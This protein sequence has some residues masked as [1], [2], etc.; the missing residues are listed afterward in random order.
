MPCFQSERLHFQYCDLPRWARGWKKLPGAIYLYYF[1]WQWLAFRAARRLNRAHRFD[2]VHHVSFVSLRAPSFMGC[3]GIPFYFGPVSGGECT[4]PSLRRNMTPP[5][6]LFEVARDCANWLMRSDPLMRLS[7][8]QAERIYVTSTDSLKLVPKKYRDKCEVHLAI[9]LTLQQLGFSRRK[10]AFGHHELRCLYA[11]RLLEWKGLHLALLAM[12]RL[13]TQGAPACFTIIGNGPAKAS[14]QSLANQLGIAS[15]ITWHPWLPHE[16][17]QRKLHEHDVF[18]FPS[19]RDSGGMAVLE[20]LAHGLPV[21]CT[22]LG[23]PAEIVNSHCGRV[24]AT[25]DR[26]ADIIA[27]DLAERLSELAANP[28]LRQSL[29]VGARRRAWDFE[30]RHLV[31]AVYGAPAN[32]SVVAENVPA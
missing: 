26:S 7:F 19:L 29:S 11:G 20:A 14:L 6:R 28:G 4:P 25:K 27:N 31:E 10:L 13:Q 32:A 21:I 1:L 16:E 8:C 17:V 2:R 15:W 24:I 9:G 12:Q 18:L 22:D 23:G 3:L 5:A 30:F